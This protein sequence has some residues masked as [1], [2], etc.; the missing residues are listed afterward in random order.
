MTNRQIHLGGSIEMNR[1]RLIAL[2][3]LVFILIPFHAR[4]EEVIKSG[5]TLD[6]RRCIEI[7]LAREPSITAA[8]SIVRANESR[9]GQA[10]SN[11]Y[12]QV[13]WT[14]TYARNSAIYSVANISGGSGEASDNYASRLNLTQNIYD[15]GKTST[16]VDIQGLNTASARQDLASVTSQIVFTVKQCYFGLLEATKNRDIALETVDQFQQHLQQAKGFHAV[17]LRPKFD[18]TKAEVDASTAKLNLLTAENNVAIARVNLSKAM[19]VPEAP[20]YSIEDNL[21]YE[22]YEISF[23]EALQ[24]A[25]AQ[26]SDLKSFVLRKESLKKSVELAKTSYYPA[27]AGVADYGYEGQEF[28]LSEGWTLGAQLN[29][30]LFSGNL[31]RYQVEE[32]KANLDTVRANE[33]SLR[34]SIYLEIRQAYLNLLLAKEQISTTALAVRQAN[35]NLSLAKGRYRVGVGN[36]IEVTDSLV[37]QANAR[38]ANVASLYN[39]KLA[40]AGIEKAMG[41][42]K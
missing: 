37:A 19:G 22:P 40:Q 41:I 2:F 23:D 1:D 6:I 17:G 29:V 25:Y 38:M 13:N 35:E 10:T 14:T 28:P 24:K 30:P 7:A 11:Y 26:R 21:F 5:V 34:Q 9:V 12:P 27:L 32:A 4:A 42:L 33:E 8:T 18:V 16:Q 31:T 39:F 15:F 20:E 36:P 3:L